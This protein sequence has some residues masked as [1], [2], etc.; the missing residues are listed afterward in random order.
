MTELTT[1]DEARNNPRATR[2]EMF[3]FILA[4]LDYAEAN[5]SYANYGSLTL[6]DLEKELLHRHS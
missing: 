6:P 4:D 2:Q 5:I 3:D 1:Q